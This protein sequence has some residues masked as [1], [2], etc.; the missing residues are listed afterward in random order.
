MFPWPGLPPVDLIRS[1]RRDGSHWGGVLLDFWTGASTRTGD[2]SKSLVGWGSGDRDRVVASGSN[3]PAFRGATVPID[4]TD[5]AG[6]EAGD[7]L[8]T[9][10]ACFAAELSTMPLRRRPEGRCA[11][12]WITSERVS[13]VGSL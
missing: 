6:G 12:S 7:S 11:A 10:A 9:S 2:L 8:F 1:H 4:R 3:S 13:G 5:A